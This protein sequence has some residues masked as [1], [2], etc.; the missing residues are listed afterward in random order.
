MHLRC[1]SI[2]ARAQIKVVELIV[3]HPRVLESL[4]KAQEMSKLCIF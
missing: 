2:T 1:C 4:K 3:A